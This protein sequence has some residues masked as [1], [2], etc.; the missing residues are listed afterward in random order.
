MCVKKR[1]YCKVTGKLYSH[2]DVDLVI[3]LNMH[4]Q[5]IDAWLSFCRWQ[6]FGSQAFYMLCIHFVVPL[7]QVKIYRLCSLNNEEFCVAV[8]PLVSGGSPPSD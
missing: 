4:T 5:G 8:S 7:V 3:V 2:C 6:A 1:Q